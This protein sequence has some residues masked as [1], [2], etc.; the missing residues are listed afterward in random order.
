MATLNYS[1]LV[2]VVHSVGASGTG[3]HTAPDREQVQGDDRRDYRA[4][5]GHQRMGMPGRNADYGDAR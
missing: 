4:A 3:W 2:M 1:E 5:G